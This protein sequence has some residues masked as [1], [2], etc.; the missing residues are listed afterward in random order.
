MEST[1]FGLEIA[2]EHRNYLPMYGP[3]FAAFYY[4]LNPL[5][6]ADLLTIRRSI[7]ALLLILFSVATFSR[8]SD[9][10]NPYDLYSSEIRHHPNSAR[11]NLEMANMLSS[12]ET[13]SKEA[14]KSNYLLARSYYEKST[15][16]NPNF[17]NGLIGLIQT[18]SKNGNPIESVWMEKLTYRLKNSPLAANTTDQLITLV[19]CQMEGICKLP[20]QQL[21]NLLL[22]SLENKT[23]TKIRRASLL[24]AY[25]YYLINISKDYPKAIQ[26]MLKSIEESPKDLD[27]RLNFIKFAI[28]TGYLSPARTQIDEF[29]K[30]DLTRKYAEEIEEQSKNLKQASVEILES[31]K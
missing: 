31:T 24:S 25:S 27:Y 10:A 29:K 7:A 12:I 30:V 13:K 20:N 6:F 1:I 8:S 4:L 22:A 18:S 16:L 14:T 15:E 3:I 17:V 2:H 21:E 11:I 26:I 28:A 9:W 5:K 19:T 23:V